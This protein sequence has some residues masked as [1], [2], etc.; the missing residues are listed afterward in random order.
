MYGAAA[1]SM[2]AQ[3][4]NFLLLLIFSKKALQS[5]ISVSVSNQS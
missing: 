4:L 3:F 2:F 1:T 5:P